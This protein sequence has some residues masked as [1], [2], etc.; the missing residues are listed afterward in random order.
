MA[1]AGLLVFVAGLCLG[2]VQETD[3][4]FRLASGEQ[5]L[6]TGRS[7]TAT[8]F[9]S[10]FPRRPTSTAPGC[11]TPRRRCFRAGR[12]SRRR[13]RQDAGGGPDR[14]A[15]VSHLPPPGRLC[16][17]LVAGPGARLLCMRERLV[18]RP[19]IF[20]LLGEVVVLGSFP[21]IEKGEPPHVAAT[22]ARCA[23]GESSRGRL[24]CGGAAGPGGR[25]RLPRP[26]QARVC[27]R[28]FAFAILSLLALLATP[29]GTGIVP[30]PCLSRRHLRPASRRRISQPD[31]AFG[32]ALHSFRA[33]HALLLLARR[34]TWL[35]RCP[36]S[37]C[38]RSARGTFA[39]APTRSWFSPWSRRHPLRRWSGRFEG[40]RRAP[41]EAVL[42]AV[43]AA[44]ALAPRIAEAAAVD[45][46]WPSASTRAPCPSTP[47]VSSRSTDCANACTTISRPAPTCCGKAI[48]ATACSW[49]R[50]C[51][52]TPSR[53]IACSA[54]WTSRARNGA[55]RWTARRGERPAR[56]RRHQP[57]RGLLG[58]RRWAL[59]FRAK[60]SRVFVRRLPN[61]RI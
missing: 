39:S 40:A 60:D 41:A 57:P 18:E 8:S 38:S 58:S 50:A 31:L 15:R 3:L 25:G 1:L 14:G 22:S 4:F 7:F 21:S 23:V 45:D 27:L 30:L 48:H 59:V 10:P 11:S 36:R 52:P 2:P 13:D 37:D 49:I 17:R 12:L 51:P 29:V 61:G 33:G 44:A 56:L 34:Q 54:A 43:L 32:C 28:F 55:R 16:L 5:F 47:S 26:G 42:L 20:S 35:Q 46:S 24:P 9:P 53:S 19:H 6:R